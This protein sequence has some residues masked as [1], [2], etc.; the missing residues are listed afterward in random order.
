MRASREQKRKADQKV[1]MIVKVETTQVVN[2]M[3]NH[4]W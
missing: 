1:Q 4:L 3:M 2:K